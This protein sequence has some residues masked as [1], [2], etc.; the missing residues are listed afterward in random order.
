MMGGLLSL[1]EAHVLESTLV[2]H[3]DS[4]DVSMLETYANY[5]KLRF[6]ITQIESVYKYIVVYTY[7]NI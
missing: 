3:Q 1:C 7:I 2:I 4:T 5:I 6:L